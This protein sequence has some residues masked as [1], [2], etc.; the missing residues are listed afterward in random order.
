MISNRTPCSR[1]PLGCF[2][3][4]GGRIF[5]RQA[6]YK[7]ANCKYINELISF[8]LKKREVLNFLT[9]K[10]QIENLT[11]KEELHLKHN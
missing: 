1:K 10:M 5:C 6:V 9:L 3:T 7:I 2:R 4:T 8:L 11:L